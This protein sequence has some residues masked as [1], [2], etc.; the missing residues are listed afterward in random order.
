[1]PKDGIPKPIFIPTAEKISALKLALSSEEDDLLSVLQFHFGAETKNGLLESVSQGLSSYERVDG[2]LATETREVIKQTLPDFWSTLRLYIRGKNSASRNIESIRHL[3]G[4]IFNLQPNKIRKILS[5]LKPKDMGQFILTFEHLYFNTG[6]DDYEKA[7]ATFLKWMAVFESRAPWGESVQAQWDYINYFLTKAPDGPQLKTVPNKRLDESA[8]GGLTRVILTREGNCMQINGMLAHI[9]ASRLGLIHWSSIQATNFIDSHILLFYPDIQNHRLNSFDPHSKIQTGFADT[10]K[11]ERHEASL[12]N[13]KTNWFSVRLTDLAIKDYN[14]GRWGE[15]KRKFLMAIEINPHGLYEKVQLAFYL[16][17][18]AHSKKY[19]ASVLDDLNRSKEIFESARGN[20]RQS[21]SSFKE[22]IDGNLGLIAMA[23]KDYDKASY[24]FSQAHRAN[25][26]KH[27]YLFG[28]AGVELVKNNQ[29]K[30]EEYLEAAIRQADKQVGKNKKLGAYI[31]AQ[32]CHQLRHPLAIIYYSRAIMLRTDLKT[33]EGYI[34]YLI[35]S[36][37]LDEANSLNEKMKSVFGSTT[38]ELWRNKIED[39]KNNLGPDVSNNVTTLSAL[40]MGA[41]IPDLFTHDKMP[42]IGVLLLAGLC[43]SI[44]GVIK[45]RIHD[46]EFAEKLDKALNPYE[47]AMDDAIADFYDLVMT[48]HRER[49]K[50]SEPE[51]GKPYYII[52]EGPVPEQTAFYNDWLISKNMADPAFANRLLK[53]VDIIKGCFK[54]ILTEAYCRLNQAST[55]ESLIT[56]YQYY[57]RLVRDMCEEFFKIDQPLLDLMINIMG[58]ELD[59]CKNISAQLLIAAIPDKQ[60]I[61]NLQLKA[62]FVDKFDEIEAIFNEVE[63]RAAARIDGFVQ[64]R[65]RPS[66]IIDLSLDENEF[67][68]EPLKNRNE[69]ATLTTEAKPEITRRSINNDKRLSVTNERKMRLLQSHRAKQAVRFF[70]RN[71]PLIPQPKN[72]VIRTQRFLSASKSNHR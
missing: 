48:T 59:K 53:H 47:W 42:T 23:L 38:H 37:N 2:Q 50:I 19:D 31:A 69:R 22:N 36:G 29:E 13:P 34:S 7:L 44:Y 66:R 9:F 49:S 62:I 4:N 27:T 35:E 57:M 33:F 6:N 41:D 8:Q 70:Q 51:Y 20:L 54:R 52:K 39:L 30:A 56:A 58:E 72:R 32:L 67:V 71:N 63:S 18:H 28:M 17:R 25:P 55:R 61:S 43:Y 16:R 1:M 14:E 24:Y 40:L 64:A 10:I 3:V 15:A 5:E 60:V 46:K 68:G 65:N 21:E 11:I 12:S 45:Q 26:K